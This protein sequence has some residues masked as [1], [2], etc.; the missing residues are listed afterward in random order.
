MSNIVNRGSQGFPVLV[1]YLGLPAILVLGQ[2]KDRP[3]FLIVLNFAKT[4]NVASRLS[5]DSEMT[6]SCSLSPASLVAVQA[7]N[8][9]RSTCVRSLPPSVHFFSRPL[10]I[11]VVASWRSQRTVSVTVVAGILDQWPFQK[12][13]F[14]DKLKPKSKE[15]QREELK[16]ALYEFIEPLDRGAAAS[17]ME[18]EAVDQLARKLEGVNPTP[19]PLKSPLASGKWKLVYTTSEEILKSKRPKALRPN[20]AIFQCID[21]NSLQ[22]QNIETWPYF[23]Q[24]QATLTPLSNSKVAVKFDKFKIGGTVPVNAPETA[25]GEIEITYLDKDLRI[26]RGNKGNL[27]ILTMEDPEYRIEA[28]KG[29]EE[30]EQPAK[31]KVFL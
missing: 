21:C 18:Q 24:V 31:K 9:G 16:Q 4:L 29:N 6:T 2:D 5:S 30:E 8:N 26:T 23:N 17:T 25:R 1:L 22:A 11:A 3:S 28:P 15:K 7:Q 20:G 10:P 27:F 19:Q 14:F 13:D 12:T